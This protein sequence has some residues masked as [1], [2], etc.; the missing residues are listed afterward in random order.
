MNPKVAIIILNWYGWKDTIECLESIYQIDYPKYDII[1][2][3]NGSEDE[4]IEKI[5]QY[6]NGKL[7]VKSDFFTNSTKNKPIKIFEYNQKDI[8]TALKEKEIEN[9]PSNRKIILI[10]NEDNYGFAEG[11]N[12]GMRYA[13]KS[14][15]PDY[16]LLLNNDTVVDK[17]FLHELVEVAKNNKI[18]IVGPKIN[19]YY[20]PNTI[21]SIGA[22]INLW[23]GGFRTIGENE[24]DEEQYND[25][26]EVDFTIGVALLTKKKVIEL[27]GGLDPIYFANWEETDWCMRIKKKGFT[28]VC[29]PK[30]K[31]WHKT[32]RSLLTFSH[33]RMYFILRNNIIFMR[34]NSKIIHL[35]TFILFF[36]FL[37]VP[38]FI[39]GA[40]YNN[41]T[42]N[43]IKIMRMVIKA[44]KDGVTTK[45]KK[46]ESLI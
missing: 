23:I 28:V 1:V 38:S 19:N 24:I 14:L 10:K 3:D 18:G 4:S 39:F 7:D 5:K 32:S 22:K 13:I 2:I 44:V 6:F 35:P 15:N 30:S 12:I 21:Q 16:I 25:A 45:I 43:P 11:N 42:K 33:E 20:E 17:N 31:I 46:T 37:R 40:F 29:N 26:F 36:S 9:L 34:K 8:E 27:V 41:D